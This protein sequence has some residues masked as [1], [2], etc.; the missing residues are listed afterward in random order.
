VHPNE[1]VIRRAYEALDRDDM[2]GFAAMFARDAVLYGGE[3]LKV[4]GAERIAEMIWQLREMTNGTLR[5]D[6]HDVVANDDHAV[7]LHTT[8]A[9][10]NGRLLVDR[11]VYVFHVQEG[12]IREAWFSGDP[13]VQTDFYGE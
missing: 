5:W 1:L 8:R 13:R 3:G 12:Q 10:R 11:V 7:A 2:A 9:E 4:T 6:L